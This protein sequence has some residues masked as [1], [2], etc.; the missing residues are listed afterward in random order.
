MSFAPW[1]HF[2]SKIS[3]PS[4]SITYSGTPSLVSST[5]AWM[6]IPPVPSYHC[7]NALTLRSISGDLAIFPLLNSACGSMPQMFSPA[8]TITPDMAAP[9]AAS[10][11]LTRAISVDP[12]APVNTGK[13]NLMLPS[14]P[15]AVVVSTAGKVALSESASIPTA[16]TAVP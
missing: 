12:T 13:F 9:T 15:R 14:A 6:M 2:S 11:Q 16:P 10:V 5:F 1:P 7:L 3:I 4:F 8:T